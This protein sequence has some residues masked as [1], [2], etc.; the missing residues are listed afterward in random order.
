VRV[1]AGFDAIGREMQRL[2]DF[3]YCFGTI[4]DAAIEHHDEALSRRVVDDPTAWVV[5]VFAA[6]RNHAP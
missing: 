6:R 1:N 3:G 2:Y 4:A 5:V